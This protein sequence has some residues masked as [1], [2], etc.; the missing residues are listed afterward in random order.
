MLQM[1]NEMGAIAFRRMNKA[2]SKKANVR[3]DNQRLGAKYDSD[4]SNT[5][6]LYNSSV[7]NNNQA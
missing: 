4:E 6:S 2:A 7:E 5:E 1:N 3:L